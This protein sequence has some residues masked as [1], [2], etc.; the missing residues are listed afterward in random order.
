M[1]EL[2][3]VEELEDLG[4]HDVEVESVDGHAVYYYGIQYGVPHEYKAVR[5]DMADGI[6]IYHR[7]EGMEDWYYMVFIEDENTEEDD[8]EWE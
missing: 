8:W 1:N 3:I 5:C 6:E 7:H 4:V 2:T